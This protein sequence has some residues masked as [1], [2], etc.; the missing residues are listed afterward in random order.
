MIVHGQTF[1]MMKHSQKLTIGGKSGYINMR[2]MTVL[3]KQIIKFRLSLATLPKGPVRLVV[4]LVFPHSCKGLSS[5][6]MYLFKLKA[7]TIPG[8]DHDNYCTSKLVLQYRP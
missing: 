1:L 2:Y 8:I 4:S 3:Y 6:K 7:N 5:F